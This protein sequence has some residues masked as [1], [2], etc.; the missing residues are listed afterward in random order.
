MKLITHG[1]DFK[2]EINEEFII[3]YRENGIFTL[4]TCPIPAASDT[5][6]DVVEFPVCLRHLRLFP[7]FQFDTFQLMVMA[8]RNEPRMLLL[9]RGSGIG[10]AISSDRALQISPGPGSDP[11]NNSFPV[12]ISSGCCNDK[13]NGFLF[14]TA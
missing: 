5:N 10:S 3:V 13:I 14:S 2:I 12:I 7:L 1:I 9:F 8:I 6:V 11:A 4:R